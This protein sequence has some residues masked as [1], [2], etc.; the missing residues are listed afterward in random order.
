[1]KA[2][3][4]K[5]GLCRLAAGLAAAALLPLAGV[6]LPMLMLRDAMGALSACATISC[7]AAL[8]VFLLFTRGLLDLKGPDERLLL[9]GHAA[10]A[11]LLLLLRFTGLSTLSLHSGAFTVMWGGLWAFSLAAAL[12]MTVRQ[13]R[14]TRPEKTAV[15]ARGDTKAA[16]ER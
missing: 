8:P 6:V 2:Q 16:A 3:R 13:I 15:K 5:H 4:K 12:C 7:V 10:G 11:A 9:H 1:M 14:R